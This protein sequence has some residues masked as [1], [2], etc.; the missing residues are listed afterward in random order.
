MMYP[1]LNTCN[2]VIDMI[3]VH[4]LVLTMQVSMYSLRGFCP[5][6]KWLPNWSRPYTL[7]GFV[8]ATESVLRLRAYTQPSG[9]TH[10]MDGLAIAYFYA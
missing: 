10:Y 2:S 8:V 4:V 1:V 5:L 7:T 3:F 6:P 9:L